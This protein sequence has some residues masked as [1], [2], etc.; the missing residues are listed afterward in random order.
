MPRRSAAQLRQRVLDAQDVAIELL[1]KQIDLL[2]STAPVVGYI[3]GYGS[4]KTYGGAVKALQLATVNAGFEGMLVAPTHKMLVRVTLAAFLRLAKTLIV[5]HHKQEQRI[6]L[7]N[8]SRVWYAS[9]DTPGSLEGSNLAWFTLD[10][11]RLVSREAYN[12]LLGR[13]RV[14]AAPLLQGVV[15]TTPTAGGWLQKEF[16]GGPEGRQLIRSSSRE[17][18][19]LA[20][21]YVDNLL[22]S[23]SK[24]QAKCYIDGEWSVLE[25]QVYPEFDRDL[26]LIDF[27]PRPEW[28]VV[29]GVDFGV[30]YPA[31]VLAQIVPR[32]DKIDGRIVR[33][34]S[35]ICFDEDLTG[36]LSTEALG[37]RIGK[38]FPPGMQPSLSWLACDPAGATMSSSASEHG[39]IMDV[40][41]LKNG[42]KDQGL[43]DVPVRYVRGPATKQIRSIAS[44]VEK[45]RAR[46]CNAKG[47]TSLYFAKSLQDSKGRERG[48]LRAMTGLVYG[49]GS[50]KIVR[51]ARA[52]QLDHISDALRYLIRHIDSRGSGTF[53]AV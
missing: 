13:L 38:R 16:D 49:Q 10:E 7:C 37:M 12:I 21:G 17:N 25:G 19:F 4:G 28:P 47:E 34:G 41:A 48:V 45:V 30:R 46:L 8:G 51:G 22:Q 35:L 1:P 23:Y 39:G 36:M 6:D 29:G 5:E 2:N 11:A 33:E 9:A 40:L 50:Q 15:T 18:F 24:A 52:Y 27:T 3:G 43:G 32:T 14:G 26:H 42:L 31:V 20:E 44:G 53:Q